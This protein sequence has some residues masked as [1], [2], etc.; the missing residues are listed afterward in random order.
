MLIKGND[1]IWSP[2]ERAQLMERALEVYLSK[3]TVTKVSDVE[4][5]H[6]ATRLDKTFFEVE[7]STSGDE[8]DVTCSSSDENL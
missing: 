3:R 7:S 2:A 8:N 6:N 1:K 5:S 4:P